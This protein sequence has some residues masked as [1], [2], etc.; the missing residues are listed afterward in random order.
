MI[1]LLGFYYIAL[2]NKVEQMD[3]FATP[4]FSYIAITCCVKMSLE[5]NMSKRKIKVVCKTI[6]ALACLAGVTTPRSTYSMCIFAEVRTVSNPGSHYSHYMHDV[7][8]PGPSHEFHSLGS[9]LAKPP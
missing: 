3:D 5:R 2:P 7:L 1:V 9:I 8:R 4:F 6:P